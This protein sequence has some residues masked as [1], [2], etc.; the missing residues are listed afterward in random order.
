M[1]LYSWSPSHGTPLGRSGT[2]LQ[3][4]FEL[5]FTVRGNAPGG[6]IDRRVHG[7]DGLVWAVR[8]LPGGSCNINSMNTCTWG[9]V[10]PFATLAEKA[11]HICTTNTMNTLLKMGGYSSTT[12]C[13][14]W[15]DR[16]IY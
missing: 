15:D 6:N 2:R 14:Y 3:C 11:L 12:M 1:E 7:R 10:T 4:I 16:L 8:L 9:I 13:Q 5:L